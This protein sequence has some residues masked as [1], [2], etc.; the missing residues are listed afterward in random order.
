MRRDNKGHLIF[1]EFLVLEVFFGVAAFGLLS[2]ALF[3]WVFAAPSSSSSSEKEAAEVAVPVVS[4]MS[5]EEYQVEAS[6]IMAP[7][8]KQASAMTQADVNRG[9]PAF[10]ALAIQTQDRLLGMERLPKAAQDEHLAFVLLLDK[11]KRALGGSKADALTVLAK[12]KQ[13]L[14]DHDWLVPSAGAASLPKDR[15]SGVK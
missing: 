12:T 4:A 11:W 10:L 9:D 6:G 8:V 13:V 14:S 1:S 5:P 7:F 3:I 15:G 2:G